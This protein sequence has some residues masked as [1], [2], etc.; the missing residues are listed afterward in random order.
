MRNFSLLVSLLLITGC[1]PEG[2]PVE[3]GP[4]GLGF[5]P[6]DLDADTRPQDD[7]FAYVNGPWIKRTE[8][9]AE[10]SRYGTMY[11]VQER[12]E[13]QIHEL[14][15][16]ITALADRPPGSD[17]QKIADLYLAFMDEA[18]AEELALEPL[19]AE[20]RRIGALET[21]D[22][23][24]NWFGRA[25]AAG[26]TVPINF[27][28]DADAADPNR[29]LAY[30]WQDGLGLPDRDYWLG[31]AADLVAVRE[32]YVAHI[33]RIYEL[34]GWSGGKRAAEEIA[35]LERR[36]AESHWTRVQNRDRETIYTNQFTLDEATELSPGF[37][38][39]AFL[40]AA[41]F[42]APET[43]VIAQTD[44]FARLGEI[45]NGTPVSAWR[46]YARFRT[47]KAFA[48]HLNRDIVLEDFDFE[49]H[50][51][52]GQQELRP[53]WKRGVRLVSG[54]VGELVGKA[55]VE[56]HFPPEAKQ[57]VEGMIE[58]LREAFGQSIATL[59]WMSEETKAAARRKLAAFN[60][61][62]GYPDVWRDYS[63]LDIVAGDLVGNVRRAKEF[64]H[65]WYIAKLTRPVDRTEWGMTPQT[66]N[67]YY[68]PTWNE[69]VFPAAI[70]QAPFF[71]FGFDDAFNYGAIGSVIGHEFSHGFDDQGRKFD[72]DG[73]LA[74]WWT[75]T[76]AE[77]HQARSVGLVRQFDAYQPRPDQS[78]NGELTLGENIADLAGLIMAYRA[79]EL[80]LG[81]EPAPVIDGFT[82]AERFFVGYAVT[83]RSKLR[84]E[85][86]MK[87]LISDPHSPPRYR[88][89]GPLK[90]M[91][92]F[93]EAYGVSDGDGMFLPEAERAKIW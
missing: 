4:G 46:E 14:L 59:E 45:I 73:R 92:E 91:P 83:W 53:R 81:G 1:A 71:D 7:F 44:Y 51:L 10:F 6:T 78:I 85:Y 69:I 25:L 20:L 61:K 5:D 16:E 30:L 47:L 82:G 24:V 79:W 13:E 65:D 68:R 42:G 84:D 62:I 11:I 93:Y 70:L 80:S 56:R 37:D 86:L 50:T 39:R 48:P 17:E 43:F 72:G 55:Y 66:V 58:H 64:E 23:V 15:G 18:R 33:R 8:I 63:G 38:W 40:A 54:G 57:R 52:R 19:A 41:R 76:D 90:N 28:V 88:V 2:P 74:D 12:T 75:K 77:Q 3:A 87:M 34:A 27:Y 49:R 67:A 22:D 21:H 26:I 89:L 36:I 32:K 35:E 9:P 31:D 60:A 29:N